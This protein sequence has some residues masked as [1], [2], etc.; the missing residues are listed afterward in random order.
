M[1][2][3]GMNLSKPGVNLV[4]QSSSISS[5]VGKTPALDFAALI[6]LISSGQAFETVKAEG[7]KN[8]IEGEKRPS[9]EELLKIMLSSATFS[10]E[11]ISGLSETDITKL[12]ENKDFA[13]LAKSFLSLLSEKSD[14][15][16]INL[17]PKNNECIAKKIA[18]KIPKVLNL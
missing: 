13:V 12:S 4:G 11:S 3:S 18:D 14:V 1:T 15:E 6:S 5:N 10:E 17:I 7:L 9:T 2:V 16:N 8:S